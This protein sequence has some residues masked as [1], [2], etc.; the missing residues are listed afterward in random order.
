MAVAAQR[1][2]TVGEIPVIDISSL[3]GDPAAE[4][5]VVAQIRRACEATGF[6]YIAHHGIAPATVAEIFRQSRRFFALPLAAR[7]AIHLT[8]SMHYRGYLPIGERGAD[9][10]RKP[11]L[12][13][14]FTV[15]REL[16]ADDPSV[17]AGVPLHGPNQWPDG[18]PGFREALLDYHGQLD[19][20]ARRL[21]VGFALALG[22]PRDGLDA[23]H[24]DPINSIRLLHYP[25][26][27]DPGFE[28]LGARPH[29]DTGIFTILL[30]DEHLGLEVA[31][32][33]GEWLVMPPI[34]G[35]FVINIA[36][37]MTALTNG[38]YAS[39]RHRVVNAYGA[40]RYSVPFFVNPDYD[41]MVAPLPQFVDHDHPAAF[42][43]YRAGDALHTLFRNLWPGAGQVDSAA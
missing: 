10:A 5:A 7:S 3:G 15:G 41:A 37:V 33:A 43:P 32:E 8:R 29:T 12:L 19:A 40:D 35:T 21:L 14:S 4:A 13:E 31:D 23:S 9:R 36:E 27:P 39:A 2:V 25:P 1:K 16:G 24:R 17:R 11:D 30:Q 38:R 18:L 34:P 20:L 22:L 26:Q 42:Q 28:L 6:F